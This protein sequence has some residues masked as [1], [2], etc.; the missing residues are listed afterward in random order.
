MTVAP[1]RPSCGVNLQTYFL[2]KFVFSFASNG[3]SHVSKV[4][5]RGHGYRPFGSF[6]FNTCAVD[7]RMAINLL[8]TTVF[9]S[10]RGEHAIFP[11]H[12]HVVIISWLGPKNIWISKKRQ[13]FSF[14]F[15]I[16]IFT[17]LEHHNIFSHV[18]F[19]LQVSLIKIVGSKF[20]F[21]FFVVSAN[22]ITDIWLVIQLLTFAYV[23][24]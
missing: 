2:Q 23:A 14:F 11:L 5:L 20:L 22:I 18:K 3:R 7:R 8:V 17:E 4:N 19:C 9:S 10:V 6:C 24:K 21:S 15:L 12:R 13:L 1:L 16:L